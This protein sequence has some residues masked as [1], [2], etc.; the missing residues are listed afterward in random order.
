MWWVDYGKKS[1]HINV[2]RYKLKPSGNQQCNTS[3]SYHSHCAVIMA[4]EL[5]HV[6]Q[7]LTGVISPSKWSKARKL[8]KKKY[9]SEYAKT[10]SKE[11]F[12]ES[13][14]A[15]IAV[16]YKTDM[17]SKDDLEK[18]NEYASN[19]FKFFDELNFNLYPM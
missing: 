10:N 16:R 4:H 3:N 6:I 1:F 7:Q 17:I 15:W 18:F 8:D 19:R 12:A 2:P 5:A 14:A 11:D 9:V 13:I